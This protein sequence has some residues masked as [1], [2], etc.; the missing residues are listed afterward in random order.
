MGGGLFRFDMRMNKLFKVRCLA[1]K[2]ENNVKDN[3]LHSRWVSTLKYYNGKLYIGTCDGLGCLDLKTDNFVNTF[4]K[5]Y[6][7][8]YYSICYS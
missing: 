2:K 8:R 6:I 7:S 1:G 4:K 5:S 3:A